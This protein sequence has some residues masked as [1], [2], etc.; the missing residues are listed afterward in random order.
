VQKAQ[1]DLHRLYEDVREY[2]APINLGWRACDLA[3]VWREAWEDL[4]ASR[5]GRQAE[6]REEVGGVDTH[7]EASPFHLRQVFRNLLDNALSVTDGPVEVVVYCTEAEIQDRRALRIK[8]RDNGPGFTEE[9]RERA[10]QPFFTTKV[11]GTGL[12]LAICARIVEAH[13]GNIAL[14]PPDGPGAAV[15]ITLPRRRA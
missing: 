14:G 2:A 11:R 10:F 4:A 5:A 6:L 1:D 8:V 12:G 9:R 3:A 13:G 15:V 7:C